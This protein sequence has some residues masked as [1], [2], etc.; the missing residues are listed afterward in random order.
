MVNFNIKDRKA[1]LKLIDS[2]IRDL[3][4]LSLSPEDSSKTN[5]LSNSIFESYLDINSKQNE[6]KKQI[7]LLQASL[8]NLSRE[9][10]YFKD[11]L[12]RLLQPDKFSLS[13]IYKVQNNIPYIKGRAYWDN[14]QREVQIGSIENVI[15]QITLLIDS[16][17]IPPIKGL[18]KKDIN[19]E[20]IKSNAALESA[21]KY[22]G[23]I[24][25]RQYILKHYKYPKGIKIKHID[26]ESTIQQPPTLNNDLTKSSPDPDFYSNWRKQNL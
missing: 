19:W 1:L 8:E 22:I 26:E 23:K 5:S 4:C 21:I 12:I 16:E 2:S 10:D 3:S 14:K 20:Y 25:F 18:K 6:L 15:S 11:S 9:S 24:K 13:L 17:I 7:N